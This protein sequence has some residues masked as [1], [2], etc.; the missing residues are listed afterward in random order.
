MLLTLDLTLEQLDRVQD[1]VHP[2]NTPLL[3][4]IHLL[5]DD[6]TDHYITLIECEPKTATLLQLL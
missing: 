5:Y 4:I 3:R 2:R 1:Y 6:L